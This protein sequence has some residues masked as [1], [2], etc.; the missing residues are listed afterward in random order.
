MVDR[1]PQAVAVFLLS[2]LSSEELAIAA[3]V[4]SRLLELA[5]CTATFIL[6][7]LRQGEISPRLL[8]GDPRPS[9]GLL[10][11]LTRPRVLVMGGRSQLDV[12]PPLKSNH[13][14]FDP[15]TL[16]WSSLS[17]LIPSRQEF[18]LEWQQ[19]FVCLVSN[20]D[21]NEEG[22]EDIVRVERFNPLS[23]RWELTQP[24]PL[25]L[26]CAASAVL[27]DEVWVVGGFDMESRER[28]LDIHI[29]R[30]TDG[31]WCWRTSEVRLTRSRSKHAC[32]ALKDELYVAGGYN[33]DY[34]YDTVDVLDT[35]TQRWREGPSMQ[36]ARRLFT[37]VVVE[38]ALCAVG[39]DL[40][41]STIERLDPVSNTWS[42]LTSVRD[43]RKFGSA[44]AFGSKIFVFGGRGHSG[45]PL[46]TWDAYDVVRGVWASEE[47]SGSDEI[48][49]SL[50]REHLFRGRC[51]TIPPTNI[52]WT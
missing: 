29:L 41:P 25:K 26:R 49:R 2:F 42:L 21:E 28:S 6:D 32:I 23:D 14:A 39:G 20:A 9:L 7:R 12:G 31:A 19:G 51:I 33:G 24:L 45:K 40:G 50:P 38:G 13:H 17:S 11:R 27:Q 37:L 43:G 10:R 34:Y 1:L 15:S 18:H 5:E 4:S 22:V 16:R 48:C 36:H 44:T 30:E 35:R 46:R 52:S 47:S 3:Y 8:A